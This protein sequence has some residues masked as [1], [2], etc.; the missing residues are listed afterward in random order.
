MQVA[1]AAAMFSER[2]ADWL[3]LLTA[4]AAT[5]NALHLAGVLEWAWRRFG[6]L[7]GWCTR[8]ACWLR[9]GTWHE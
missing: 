1:A 2:Y 3:R 5:F 8:V 6:R 9:L 7:C 4:T